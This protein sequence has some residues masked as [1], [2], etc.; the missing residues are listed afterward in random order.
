MPPTPQQQS[1]L[2]QVF[3]TLR[4]HLRGPLQDI[5]RHSIP[6][7]VAAIFLPFAFKRFLPGS[8]NQRAAEKKSKDILDAL[9]KRQKKKR[10][11][12]VN[13]HECIIASDIIM[14]ENIQVTFDDIGGLDDIKL[15]LQESVILPLK[16]PELFQRGKLLRVPR[17]ILL[18][19]EPG[20]GKTMLA[21]AISKT[22]EA[23]FINLNVA[24]LMEKWFGESEKLIYAVFSLAEKI[25]PCIIFVDEADTLF[26]SRSSSDHEVLDRIKAL[27]MTLWDGLATSPTAQVAIIAATNR[28]WAIDEAFQRRMPQTYHIGLPDQSQR[29]T[30]LKIILKGEDVEPDFDVK[31]LAEETTGYSGS[32][33]LALCQSAAR[34]PIREQLGDIVSVAIEKRPLRDLR[35]QDF[36]EAK[37][38]VGPTGASA[39]NYRMNRSAQNR[40]YNQTSQRPVTQVYNF[41]MFPVTPVNSFQPVG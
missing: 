23:A 12:T 24:N 11:I 8:E 21:K 41:N 2:N 39:N 16:Y 17:G 36:L 15:K 35:I 3:A 4:R 25:Q 6:F 1:W 13:S 5:I 30:I 7:I 14:P 38:V 40:D 37:Q 27:F 18:Y 26:R 34:A 31:R 33:L 20:T 32:D 19:G 29:E 28:P 22:S 9:L 10:T